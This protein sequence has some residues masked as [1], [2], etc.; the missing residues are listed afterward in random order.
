[1]PR[2]LKKK[3]TA[4]WRRR[5]IQSLIPRLTS[6]WTRPRAPTPAQHM[7]RLHPPLATWASGITTLPPSGGP[8]LLEDSALVEPEPRA[9]R[10]RARQS[11]ARAGLSRSEARRSAER[12]APPLAA[13]AARSAMRR[14]RSPAARSPGAQRARPP[15]APTAPPRASPAPPRP[16]AGRALP[17]WPCPCLRAASASSHVSRGGAT[18]QPCCHQGTR[19]R[20]GARPTMGSRAVLPC[21]PLRP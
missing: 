1:M 6:L 19:P 3:T 8:A 12:A 2:R 21:P 14:R 11:R 13:A 9:A 15:L 10:A 5:K 7:S 20:Q 17:A 16:P 18:A 4:H